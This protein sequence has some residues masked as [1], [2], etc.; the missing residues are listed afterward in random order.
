VVIPQTTQHQMSLKVGCVV[1]H[2]KEWLSKDECALL[3]NEC[4]KETYI[5]GTNI[6]GSAIQRLQ[7]FYQDDG[8]YF[9]PIWHQRYGRWD[10]HVY[11]PWLTQ[12]QDRLISFTNHPYNSALINLYRDG[13]D[14]ITPH[15]DD[16]PIWGKCPSIISISLG[17]TR[18]IVL[19]PVKYDPQNP[20]SIKRIDGN[21]IYYTLEAGDLFVMGGETQL[22][23]VHSIPKDLMCSDPRWNITFRQMNI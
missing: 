7:K 15:R 10:A 5:E 3:I 16:Q 2:Y 1:S 23:Y 13:N 21:N 4:K 6:S 12:L 9:S 18:T 14:V 22:H 20:R 11:P 17:A 8:I 19:E